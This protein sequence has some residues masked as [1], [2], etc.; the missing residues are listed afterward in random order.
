MVHVRHQPPARL[1]AVLMM[2]LRIKSHSATVLTTLIFQDVNQSAMMVTSHVKMVEHL[3]SHQTEHTVAVDM[4]IMADSA[5]TLIHVPLHLAR[6]ITRVKTFHQQSI[7]VSARKDFMGNIVKN[8]IA[9]IVAL[10]KMVEYVNLSRIQ[11]TPAFVTLDIME[12]LH[13]I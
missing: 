2:T 3:K 4:A 12:G 11:I 7:Y 5:N 1:E 8:W 9:V 13:Q 6:I 10:V